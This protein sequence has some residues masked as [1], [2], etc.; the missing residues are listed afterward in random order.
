MFLPSSL[1]CEGSLAAS[2]VAVSA[3]GAALVLP[4]L[5]LARRLRGPWRAFPLVAVVGEVSVLAG[6]ALVFWG[7]SPWAAVIL[8]LVGTGLVGLSLAGWLAGREHDLPP[9]RHG[10]PEGRRRG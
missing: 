3:V 6:G 2:W 8:A 7:R 4:A 5:R 10:A 9:A 1:C